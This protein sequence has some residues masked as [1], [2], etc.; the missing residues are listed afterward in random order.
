M[1]KCYV[2]GVFPPPYGGATIKCK[3]F[4]KLL[5]KNNIEIMNIDLMECPTAHC[6]RG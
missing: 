3:L 5:E 2:I 6:G 4:C 1:K